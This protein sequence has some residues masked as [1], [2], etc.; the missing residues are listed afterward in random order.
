VYGVP[1][2]ARRVLRIRVSDG[3]MDTFGP[4]FEGKFKWLRGVDIPPESMNAPEE[5]P[6]GCC[7]ALPCN[8]PSILK[9]NPFSHKVST[10][11]TDV[12]QQCG[13]KRWLYHGGVLDLGTNWVYCIPANANRVLKFNPLT[14]EVVFI[15]P[16][17]QSGYCKW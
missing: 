13:A 5:Y 10:F 17:F 6:S 12:I 15:G 2:T 8:H 3:H 7:V 14:E 4:N 11:G 16:T 1:G 9:I